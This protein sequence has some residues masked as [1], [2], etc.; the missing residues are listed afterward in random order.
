MPTTVSDVEPARQAIQE[1]AAQIMTG[2]LAPRDGA[3]RIADEAAHLAHPEEFRVFGDL[4]RDG[5]EEAILH[6][7]SL[8]LADTA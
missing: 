2:Q 7:T 1:L 6:E 8:L 3:R 4:A 5:A